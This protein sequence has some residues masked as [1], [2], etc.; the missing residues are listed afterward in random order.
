MYSRYFNLLQ[1]IEHVCTEIRF[2]FNTILTF[3]SLNLLLDLDSFN[4]EETLGGMLNDIPNHVTESS[5][6]EIKLES[7]IDGIAFKF[8]I[9]L[10][11]GNAQQFWNEITKPLC[12][13]TMELQ[14]RH[15]IL[16][17]LIRR[18]DEE[19]TEYKLGGAQLTR[20]EFSTVIR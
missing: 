2:T 6:S 14:H 4:I 18:K 1:T 16:L 7:C 8:T 19:L 13:S 20:S 10:A 15:E 11:K 3:Q 17:D 9:N 5:V 12:Q